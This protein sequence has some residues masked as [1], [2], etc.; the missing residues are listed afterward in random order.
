LDSLHLGL[1]RS[2]VRSF[3]LTRFRW[4][5]L[6]F[7]GIFTGV[8]GF[9][10]DGISDLITVSKYNYIKSYTSHPFSSENF[11]I[12]CCFFIFLN[13]GLVCLPSH[14]AHPPWALTFIKVTVATLLTTLFEPCAAGS[15]I[16][17]IKYPLL[18]SSSL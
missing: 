5:V 1:L 2:F 13:A 18:Q 15:G 4:I 12:V 6:F 7:I 16:P 9:Y 11:A 3:T 8:V 17:E 14:C 10:I